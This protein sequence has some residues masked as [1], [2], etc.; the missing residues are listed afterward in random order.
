M[1]GVRG[2]MISLSVYVFLSEYVSKSHS[3][4]YLNCALHLAKEMNVESL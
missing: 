1:L 4:L 3:V 2:S